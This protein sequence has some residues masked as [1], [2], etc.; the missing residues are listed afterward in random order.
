MTGSTSQTQ[1]G[2]ERR[3][4]GSSLAQVLVGLTLLVVGVLWLLHIT[5]AVSVSWFAVLA[6]VLMI[7]GVA[8]VIGSTSGEHA[9]LIALGVV[10]TVVLTAA[11]WVD[12][13]FEG[14]V[15]D[16]E[17]VP[18]AIEE[19]QETYRLSAGTLSLDLREVDFPQGETSVEARVGAGELIV[20]V[21]ADVAVS[22]NWRVVAGDITVLGRQQSGVFLDDQD[23][24]PGYED[25][26]RRLMLDLIVT[27]GTIEV[28]Q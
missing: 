14:G 11:T 7:V 16:R 5:G 24:T 1:E 25:A 27:T 23:L 18:A 22:V 2:M 10:L 21:P 9:G 3:Q 28:R 6:V 20:T 26:E 4:G 19:L 13:R 15:G 12:F 8:L 17:F